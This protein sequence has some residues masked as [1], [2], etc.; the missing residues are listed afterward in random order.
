MANGII[1]LLTGPAHGV[2]LVVSLWSLR[3]HY[4]G[5]VTLFTTQL[6][7]HWIGERCAGDRRLGVEH[8]TFGDAAAGRNGDFLTKLAVLPHSPYRV[9]AHLDADTLVA[10]DV[11]AL[12]ELPE[13]EPFCATQFAE[14]TT[15]KRILRR[16][17]EPWR[18]VGRDEAERA[19]LNGLV[20][21]ALERRPAVNGGVFAYRRGAEIV[22]RWRELAETGRSTFICDEIA[23]QL[24]LTQYPHKL[25]DCRYN[26][27]PIYGV[28]RDDVRIWHFHGE[29]HVDARCRELW[30]PAYEECLRK[31]VARLAQWSPG[32][33]RRL[34]AWERE[35]GA[36]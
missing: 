21:A 6:A 32:G 33:D 16:R 15:R 11:S 18:S 1:Y 30:L 4:A 20:D 31:D 24:I 12:F 35:G 9:T 10:G 36:E 13:S 34:A 17:L 29:R 2:R 28:R 26:C 7:S 5:P 25:L 3:R 8:R 14:W 19:I 27:S 22:D 23:L